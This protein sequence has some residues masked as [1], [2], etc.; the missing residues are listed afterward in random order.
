MH[1]TA[2]VSVQQ[3]LAEELQPLRRSWGWFLALGILMVL[4]GTAA[5]SWSCLVTI[6]LL[7]TWLFGFMMLAAG[8]SEVIGSFSAARWSGTLLHI[9]VGILYVVAGLFIIDHPEQSAI[10]LTLIAAIFLIVG[11]AVRVISALVERFHGW[12]WV[13]LNGVISLM[14]G[15]VI[16][17]QWPLS[18][19]WVIGL[20]IGIEMLF[21]GWAWIM[22]AVGLRNLPKVT[23]QAA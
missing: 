12:P 2:A 14:L 11:G 17:K 20:F 1:A 19:L 10:Q 9:L 13:M 21:N 6:T 8:I 18:G 23:S 5:I 22:F 3:R 15:M 4:L 7:A 16:Y